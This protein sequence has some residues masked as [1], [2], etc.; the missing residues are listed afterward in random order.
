MQSGVRHP[1]ALMAL[2]PVI[3]RTLNNMF[4]FGSTGAAL[5][6]PV[7]QGDVRTAMKHL[8]VSSRIPFSRMH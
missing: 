7:A 5:S 4:D 6:G 2:R 3:V 1:D 8:E